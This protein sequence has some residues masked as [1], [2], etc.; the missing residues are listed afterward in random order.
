MLRLGVTVIMKNPLSRRQ[1][2]CGERQN[3][4]IR[5]LTVEHHDSTHFSG[6]IDGGLAQCKMS[7]TVF[8]L[9]IHMQSL[10][11]SDSLTC[12]KFIHT[13]GRDIVI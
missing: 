3:Q 1:R 10:M 12:D 8:I 6:C 13:Y 2:K 11:H 5:S 7:D 4:R 9:G